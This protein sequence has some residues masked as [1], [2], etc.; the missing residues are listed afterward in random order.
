[1]TS[2]GDFI[3]MA[4]DESER[5]SPMSQAAWCN[6][7]DKETNAP[8]QIGHSFNGDDE[9]R[10]HFTKTRT[11]NIPTGNSY[12]RQ[13]YQER[14]EVTDSLDM[15]GYHSRKQAGLFQATPEAIE[16]PIEDI[17]A[18]S[19]QSEAEMWRAKYEAERART[20]FVANREGVTRPV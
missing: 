20:G 9:D 1:M 8:F 4:P 14:K 12:G 5:V 6:I 11:V 2:R 17:E 18:E 3:Q 15:C 7:N 10:E 19:E 16:P 13:T